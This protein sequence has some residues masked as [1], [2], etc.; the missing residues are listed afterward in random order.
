MRPEYC[1]ITPA[2]VR[3]LAQQAL[4]PVLPWQP[5]GRLL[6]VARL[7][8]ILLLV[9]A[10][11]SSLSAVVRTFRFGCSHE[12]ARQALRANLPTGPDALDTLC[13][14]LVRALHDVAALGRRDRRRRWDV[15]IDT[16]YAP[17][18]GANPTRTPGV[19]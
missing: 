9:A 1:T 18:Y 2:V 5:H 17:Y 15:A 19:V 10:L 4:T 7:L 6:G 11:R 13:E 14:G 8:G 3:R 16:H 12:T